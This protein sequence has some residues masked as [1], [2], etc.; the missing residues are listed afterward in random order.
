MSVSLSKDEFIHQQE[1]LRMA[2]C[3]NEAVFF[4]TALRWL[5]RFS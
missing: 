4:S 5:S 3:R 1:R 2:D